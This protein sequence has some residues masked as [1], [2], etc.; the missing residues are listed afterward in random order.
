MKRNHQQTDQRWQATC[1]LF[2]LNKIKFLVKLEQEAYK[3]SLQDV[4]CTVV[5]QV[6][7]GQQE[8]NAAWVC[9]WS[10]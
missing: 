9:E 5:T 8:M 3:Q 6:L 2:L 7:D 4:I 1:I 10:Y